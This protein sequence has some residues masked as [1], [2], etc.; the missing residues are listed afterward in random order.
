MSLLVL[1]DIVKIKF[2][3]GVILKWKSNQLSLVI[4]LE[5]YFWQWVLMEILFAQEQEMRHLGSGKYIIIILRIIIIPFPHFLLQNSDEYNYLIIYIYSSLI[6]IYLSL[7]NQWF[8]IISPYI[9]ISIFADISNK[10]TGMITRL[11]L[12]FQISNK[13]STDSKI[14]YFKM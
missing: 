12:N 10:R 4:L 1:M 2:I 5:S 11:F 13:H 9:V 7:N 6:I 14:R 8:L 3:Y